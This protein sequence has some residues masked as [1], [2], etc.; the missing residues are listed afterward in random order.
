MGLL[1]YFVSSSF[2]VGALN[3]LVGF[4]SLSPRALPSSPAAPTGLAVL[5]PTLGFF[6]A[7][8]RWAST[9]SSSNLTLNL[10]ASIPRA[11]Y[12]SLPGGLGVSL[13]AEF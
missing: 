4:L 1:N 5:A 11:D 6:R 7:F 2:E 10:L 13:R 3:Y 8:K 12:L 9:L